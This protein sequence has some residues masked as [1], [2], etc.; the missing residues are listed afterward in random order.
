M[1]LLEKK[2]KKKILGIQIFARIILKRI[3]ELSAEEF[4]PFVKEL[5]S[6]IGFNA[7]HVGRIGDGGFDAEGE[8]EIYNMA[9]ID[10][11]VQAKR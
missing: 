11:K 5:L 3:L 7:K 10:L 1:K 2:S 9:K 8:L 6:A 4:E